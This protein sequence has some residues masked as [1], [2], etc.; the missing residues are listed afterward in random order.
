[1][2]REIKQYET[3]GK[4]VATLRSNGKYFNGQF[5]ISFEDETFIT[6]GGS[7]DEEGQLELHIEPIDLNHWDDR[8]IIA[9]KIMSNDEIRAFRAWEEAQRVEAARRVRQQEYE[10]LKQEF[11]GG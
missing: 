2:K 3:P 5:V 1:M 11:E 6:I 9:L 7:R 4:T 8:D 10:R